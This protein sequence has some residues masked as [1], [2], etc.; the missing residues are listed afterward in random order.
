MNTTLLCRQHTDALRGM[1]AILIAL[2]HVFLEWDV[3]RSLNI[4]GSI[5]VAIFLFLSGYGLQQSYKQGGLQHYWQKRLRRIIIPFWIF[6]AITTP[7]QSEPFSW[8]AF[9][10]EMCF[11]HSR[12]WF[13]TYVVWWYAI[14]WLSVRFF[15]RYMI[16]VMTTVA[17]LS[18]NLLMQIEAEQSFSFLAGVL[19]SMSIDRLRSWNAKQLWSISLACLALGA[20]LVLLKEIPAVHALKGTLTYNYILLFIKLPLAIP[21]ILISSRVQWFL[22]LRLLYLCGISSMEIYLVHLL[23]VEHVD[24]TLLHFTAFLLLTALGTWLMYRLDCLLRR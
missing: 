22:H 16:A 20:G 7:L 17:L 24:C 1:A 23:F 4:V 19:A 5:C 3:H 10:L 2:F 6:I 12:Y 14:Y 21:I 8:Q 18:L 9:I 13:I 15:P 11:V